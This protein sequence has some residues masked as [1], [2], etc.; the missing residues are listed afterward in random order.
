MR[1]RPRVAL[2]QERPADRRSGPLDVGVRD[3]VELQLALL[4]QGGLG[5]DRFCGGAPFLGGGE[6]ELGVAIE[7]GQQERLVVL[8]AELAE[9]AEQVRKPRHASDEAVRLA[10]A[11]PP[12]DRPARRL[13]ALGRVPE[14]LEAL[15]VQHGEVAGLVHHEHRRDLR[16]RVEIVARGVALL[17]QLRVVVAHADDPARPG[18]DGGGLL[19]PGAQRG[20]QGGD[21]GDLAVRRRQEIRRGGLHAD[22]EDVAVRVDEP[23]EHRLAAQVHDLGRSA[24]QPQDLVRSADGQDLAVLHG[25]RP[26]RRMGVV[27]GDDGA[28]GVDRRGDVPGHFRRA[29]DRESHRRHE[30]QS[31]NAPD[32]LFSLGGSGRARQTGFGPRGRTP[33][34]LALATQVPTA[35]GAAERAGRRPAPG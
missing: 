2:R 23:G 22:V 25:D 17:A 32:H 21:V 6:A 31:R 26:C 8:A 19:G 34:A 16:H 30:G 28:A 14:G 11:F 9:L 5:G 1:K 7:A 13:D 10:A 20:L 18:H 35:P 24:L 12:A 15:A 27:D 3:D 33:R 29:G 4:G